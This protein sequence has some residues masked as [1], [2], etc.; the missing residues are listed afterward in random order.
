[1]ANAADRQMT[2]RLYELVEQLDDDQRHVVHLHYYQQLSLRQTAQ[3]LNVTTSTVKHR[4]R[5]VLAI[6]RARLGVAGNEADV[7][8]TIPAAKGET[9]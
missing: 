5:E 7:T 1:M 8:R 9:A 3:V 6:L 4:L 2:Q